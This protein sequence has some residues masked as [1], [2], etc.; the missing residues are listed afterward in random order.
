MPGNSQS[1]ELTFF[2]NTW[3]KLNR[4]KEKEQ[5]CCLRKTVPMESANK[6]VDSSEGHKGYIIYLQSNCLCSTLLSKLFWLPSLN[7]CWKMTCIL[8]ERVVILWTSTAW[9]SMSSA[10][11]IP[12]HSQSCCWIWFT[13][14]E[15][16]TYCELINWRPCQ[17]AWSS[18]IKF[19]VVP[20]TS[21]FSRK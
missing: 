7:I 1:K 6:R 11:I 10:T 21:N 19:V 9:G 17:I 14:Y 4:R 18:A 13:N 16:E 12:Y 5:S 15:S 2:F 20:V 8:V 3:D